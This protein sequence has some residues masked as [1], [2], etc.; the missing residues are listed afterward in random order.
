MLKTIDVLVDDEEDIEDIRNLSLGDSLSLEAINFNFSEYNYDCYLS[1]LL[2]MADK[3][4][5]MSKNVAFSIS[6]DCSLII[7]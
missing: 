2:N 7:D 4:S 6:A 3:I 5:Y 1:D